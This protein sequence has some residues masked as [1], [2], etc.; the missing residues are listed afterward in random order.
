VSHDSIA[1]LWRRFCL[2]PHRVEGFTFSTDPELEAKIRDVVGLYLDLP[3]GAVVVCV[4]ERSQTL[5]RTQP[6]LPMQLDLGQGPA[7]GD[8]EALARH[9]QV[10]PCRPRQRLLH[11]HQL[12]SVPIGADR[13]HGR[14][15]C[16]EDVSHSPT[17]HTLHCRPDRF[18]YRST[19]LRRRRLLAGLRGRL[20]PGR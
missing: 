5:D 20:A 16:I 19:S 4:D 10:P 12:D 1:A 8:V 14:R 11:H 7:I 9:A 17:A 15:V 18:S 13:R 2:Q 6:I 3:K